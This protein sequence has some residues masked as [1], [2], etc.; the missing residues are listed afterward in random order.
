MPEPDRVRGL[1]DAGIALTSELSLDDLLRKLTETAAALTGARYAALGVIDPFGTGLERFVTTGID[2]ETVARI[3]QLPRGRGILGAL[4]TDA[5][6]VRLESIADD[7]RSVGFPPHH[8]PMRGFLGVPVLLR[9]RAYGNLYLTEKESGSFTAEDQELVETLASQAAVAIENARLYEAA[10]S[11]SNQLE[12][13]NEVGTAL[14]SEIELVPLLELIA[15]R[16]RGL[17]D[18]RLVTIALPAADGT[19][20]IEAADGERADEIIGMQL[21]RAG[22]KSGRVLERLRAERV[23]ALADDREVDQDAITRLGAKAGLFVPLALGR[24]A[25]GVIVAHDK[26]REDPRFSDE[27]LRLA[28][29]FAPRAAVAVD[30]SARVASDAL[31]RIVEAQELERRRLA[32]ELHDQT[33]QE[34]TSVLLGLKAVEEARTDEERAQ[35]LATVREQVVE[36]LHDVRRLAVELR[37][38]AL[39]DFGLVAALERL[40]DTFAERTRMRVDLEANV[41]SRLPSDVETALYRIVQEAL[42]NI[43]KHAEASAVSIVLARRER[44]ITAVIEDDGRGF[45]PE[46][47]GDGLGLLGM[48]ERL[49]LLRGTIKI[50]SSPGAGTTIVAEVPLR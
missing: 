41:G 28:E 2:S 3:G 45:T 26:Q 31:G 38:K 48:R 1:V 49:A 42:T 8:P 6:S 24:R 46:A 25:I 32:R 4:I 11:W 37:P 7:P 27:D 15:S 47:D 17:I 36:T 35:S 40:R 30:L 29:T 16:L 22:S 39:D 21:E 50:E 10:T 9:G 13:L 23:D 5:R 34:L 43:V 12:A 19:L 44:S 33:G 18:A 20:R 14:A